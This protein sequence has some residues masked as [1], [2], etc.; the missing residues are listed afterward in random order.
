MTTGTRG[1]E[2]QGE[3]QSARSLVGEIW[4]SRRLIVMLSRKDFFVRYRRASFGMLWTVGLPL[5]QAAVLAVVFT[6]VVRIDAGA[7]FPTFLFAGIVPFT[8]F[9]ESLNA[10]TTSIVSGSDL[11][12]KVYFPRAVFPLVVAGTN[13]LSLPATISVLIVMALGFGV[14]L[15][16]V[17]LLWLIPGVVLLFALSAGFALVLSALYVYFRDLQY[18]VQAALL[19][20]FYASPILYPLRLAPEELRIVL[21]INPITGVI[22]FFRAA[23]VGADPGWLTAVLST[24]LWTIALL[25]AAVFLHRRFNRVFTDLL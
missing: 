9:R 10:G 8:F 12:T 14:P 5:I 25:I 17:E 21:Y 3:A 16:A 18:V 1:F 19:A 13:T 24:V 11:A 15:N 4:A 22:E 23:I 20:W 6:R 2:M 7:N